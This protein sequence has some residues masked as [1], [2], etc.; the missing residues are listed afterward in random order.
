MHF[1]PSK[2][3]EHI[4]YYE[5]T[6]AVVSQGYSIRQSVQEEDTYGVNLYATLS[7]DA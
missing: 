6:T 2:V 7:V 4:V 3:Y 1:S 5:F